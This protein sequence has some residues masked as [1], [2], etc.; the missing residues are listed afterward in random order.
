MLIRI[1]FKQSTS[2]FNPRYLLQDDKG[3]TTILAVHSKD[4]PTSTHTPKQLKWI[5]I[6]IPDQWKIDITQPPRNFEQR[7][8]T[9][10]TEQYD[11]KILLKF[12]SFRDPSSLK[13]SSYYPRSSFSDYMTSQVSTNS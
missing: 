12:G 8:I 10:I 6:T 9:R 5:E 2:E 11:G 1:Y 4:T 3:E 13:I 7:T